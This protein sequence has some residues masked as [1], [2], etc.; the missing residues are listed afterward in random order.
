MK[1]LLLLLLAA[2]ALPV[3]V[4]AERKLKFRSIQSVEM[5]PTFQVKDRVIVDNNA[6]L[7][8][9]PKR[10]EII[11]FKSPHGFDE[12]LVSLR[13]TPL[14]SKCLIGS[15]DIACE[16][17]MSRIV[18]ISGDKVEVTS[19]GKLFINDSQIN[20]P[21]V[22]YYCMKSICAKAVKIVVPY[23]H[24]FVL[25]DNRSNSWDSR[26]WPNYFLPVQ[27]IEGKI[28]R[29]YWPLERAGLINEITSPDYRLP[30]N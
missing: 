26:Y 7:N 16:V 11:T 4:N 5:S 25:G 30:A 19:K 12:T 2:L 28:T 27:K 20:E 8:N 14:P 9:A 6:Y 24:V 23:D 17:Y 18:A 10:G 1:R 3:A 22:K 21:Y 13:K 29:I 15:K